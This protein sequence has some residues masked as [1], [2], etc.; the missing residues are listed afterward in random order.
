MKIGNF[1]FIR[2]PEHEGSSDD[3]GSFLESEADEASLESP[4][5][6]EPT[7]SSGKESSLESD[8]ESMSMINFRA[9]HHG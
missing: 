5:N 7:Y 1:H 4:F 2:F 9:G 3:E 8:Y 6:S